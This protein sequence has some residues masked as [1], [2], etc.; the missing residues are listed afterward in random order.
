MKPEIKLYYVVPFVFLVILILITLLLSG[1]KP[2]TTKPTPTSVALP[3]TFNPVTDVEQDIPATDPDSSPTPI[4]VSDST[5]VSE[6]QNIP[7]EETNLAIQKKDLRQQIPYTGSVFTI[8]FD[9]SQDLFVVTLN[10]PKEEAKIQFDE[11][12][13]NTYPAIPQDRFMIN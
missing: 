1:K 5:G 13:K 8:T 10:E 3:T 2:T 4:P 12:L 7:P 6:E 11:W 9:Y